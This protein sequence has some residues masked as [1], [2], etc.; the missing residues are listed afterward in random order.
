MQA[1][2][3]LSFVCGSMFSLLAVVSAHAQSAYPNRPIRLVVPYA[4]GGGVDQM[5]RALGDRLQKKTGQSVIIENRPGAST[6]IGMA[7]VV[8]AKPDGYTLLMA[9][10]PMVVNPS[11]STK[12]TFNPKVDLVPITLIGT[13]P[14]LLVVHPSIPAKSV[15][16]LIKYAKANPRTLNYASVGAG[17]STHLAAELFKEMAGVDI[18]HIPYN[19]SAP[20]YLDLVTG[21]VQIM[22]S[23]MIT[24]LPYVKQGK[25]RALAV[26]TPARSPAA[27]ELPTIAESGL[28]GYDVTSFY[29]LMAPKGTPP[30]IIAKLRDLVAAEMRAPGVAEQFSGDGVEIVAGSTKEFDAFLK[31]EYDKWARVVKTSGIT[32]D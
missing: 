15:H 10:T 13:Y 4:P 32:V 6:N 2:R 16:E 19:G 11:L 27:P 28:A 7:N 14:T 20:A 17:S 8:A 23:T 26:T 24:G 5:A 30:D 22:F 9:T 18:T 31:R 25:L 12:L 1:S 29:G 21:R 3:L